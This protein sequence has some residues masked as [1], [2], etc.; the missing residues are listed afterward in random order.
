MDG[1]EDLKLNKKK[2]QSYRL[3][4][5]IRVKEQGACDETESDMPKFV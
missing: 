2:P 1:W 5:K 3:G 4:R